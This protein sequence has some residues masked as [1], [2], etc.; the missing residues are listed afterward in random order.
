MNPPCRFVHYWIIL[1]SNYY[2]LNIITFYKTIYLNEEVNRTEP[3]PLVSEKLYDKASMLHNFTRVGSGLTQKIRLD[4]KV[5]PGK[6][7]L[8]SYET[9]INNGHVTLAPGRIHRNERNN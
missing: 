6:N 3:S 4:C 5:L 9:L 2:Q 7:T 1:F 8:A